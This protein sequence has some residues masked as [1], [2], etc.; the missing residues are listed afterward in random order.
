MYSLLSHYDFKVPSEDMVQ[1]DDL[2][3]IQTQYQGEMDAARE[4]NEEK[5]P[6]MVRDLDTNIARLND[7]LVQLGAQLDEGVFTDAVHFSNPGPVLAELEKVKAKLDQVEGLE[8]QYSAYQALF[9]ITVYSYKN[10]VKTQEKFDQMNGLWQMVNRWNEK[11]E[12]WMNDSFV[13]L[14]AEEMNTE[15]QVF[16]K[17]SFAAHKKMNCD[18]TGRL[19]EV[20]QD[21]KAK[22]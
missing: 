2:R 6:D 11:Y 17:D 19:K 16:V 1:V 4:E 10:L 12:S 18:V 13:S 22:M 20:T 8:K 15:V 14:N 9:G 5:M 7:Q 3:T 21:F